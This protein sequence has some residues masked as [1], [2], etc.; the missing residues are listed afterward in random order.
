M[1][2]LDENPLDKEETGIANQFNV[3][4]VP[5]QLV[6][7]MWDV[8]A[9]HLMRGMTVAPEL[10]FSM[11]GDGLVDQSIQLWIVTESF[12]DRP[13]KVIAAFLS[14]VEW[15]RGGWV[16]SLFALGGERP[17][18]WVGA[19]HEAAHE[20]AQAMDAER[21]RMAGRPAWQRILPGYAVTGERGSHLVYERKV[22]GL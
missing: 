21:V 19:C 22:E 16:L 11:V 2:S 14:S 15:D 18:K 7:E 5:Y 4:R 3:I 9:P 10:T 1:Q 12:E 20:F 8:A 6:G 13:P 17:Q